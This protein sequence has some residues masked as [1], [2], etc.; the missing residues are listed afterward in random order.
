ML[1]ALTRITRLYRLVLGW[2]SSGGGP[3][4]AKARSVG[5][6][7][8][9]VGARGV[10]VRIDCG[11]YELPGH[12]S[13]VQA[14]GPVGCLRL[15]L[16]RNDERGTRG[17]LCHLDRAGQ[18]PQKAHPWADVRE[19]VYEIPLVLLGACRNRCIECLLDSGMAARKRKSAPEGTS[20]AIAAPAV[21]LGRHRGPLPL[22]LP[23]SSTSTTAN[24]APLRVVSR[25]NPA[26]REPTDR[27]A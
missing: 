17:F 10:N 22:L 12:H 20:R 9:P 25:P 27:S 16:V 18:G 5:L 13:E 15:R 11:P 1:R 19:M 6:T 4:E 2:T 8:V 3:H 21:E 23:I 7:E 14:V 24:G 26:F